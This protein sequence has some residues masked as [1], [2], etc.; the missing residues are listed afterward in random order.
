MLDLALTF[1]KDELSSYLA[2]RIVPSQADVKL[3]AV[4]EETGKYAFNPDTIGITLLNA[5]S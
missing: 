3:T 2:S 4:A 5:E 1:L